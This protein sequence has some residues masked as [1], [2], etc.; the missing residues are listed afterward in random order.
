MLQFQDSDQLAWSTRHGRV[1]F[2]HDADLLR[3]HAIHPNHS[4]IVYAKP[5]T[6]SLGE[7]VRGLVLIHE[8]LTEAEMIGRLEFL[9]KVSK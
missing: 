8:L 1:L 2:T 4:G 5:L 3:L 9:P 7:I 6:L